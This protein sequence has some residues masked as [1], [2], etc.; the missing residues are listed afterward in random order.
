[1]GAG[2]LLEALKRFGEKCGLNMSGQFTRADILKL[3]A[4]P[5]DIFF[6]NL[7]WASYTDLPETYRTFVRK[8]FVR[9]GLADDPRQLF[10]GGSRVDLAVLVVRKCIA[11]F[12]K[13]A[14]D[15]IVFMFLSL[16]LNEEASRKFHSYRAGDTA[17][18]PQR[19]ID[20]QGT[21]IYSG[22]FTRFGLAHFRRDARVCFPVPR[23]K[24][25]NQQWIMRPAQPLLQPDN[26]LSV[27]D[28]AADHPLITRENF[29]ENKPQLRKWVLLPYR[30]EGKP[31]TAA[32]VHK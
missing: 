17:Y 5:S 15:A 8:K 13:P 7:P 10:L 31:L 25:E 6:G 19:V 27:L 16:L 4:F 20:L 32:E 21:G 1:M 9:T 14:G 28:E 23:E 11:D 30:K 12:L 26:P 22:V 29:T 24:R 18:V 2:H 3:S